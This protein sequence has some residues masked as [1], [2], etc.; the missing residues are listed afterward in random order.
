MA[1]SASRE[2]FESPDNWRD[3][4]RDGNPSLSSLW[5]R[6]ESRSAE[7][8]PI[9]LADEK[10]SGAP[11]IPRGQPSPA[12]R[13]AGDGPLTDR[14]RPHSDSIAPPLERKGQ[15]ECSRL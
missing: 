3:C 8:Q 15:M 4:L 6:S 9:K 2:D 10:S 11:R 14:H 7:P 12:A 13:R 1:P 5:W